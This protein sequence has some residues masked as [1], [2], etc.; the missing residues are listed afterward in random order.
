MQNI[1]AKFQRFKGKLLMFLGIQIH[2]SIVKENS[3]INI[4]AE[5]MVL[6]L[7]RKTN[8][9]VLNKRNSKKNIS[10][11]LDRNKCLFHSEEED[12]NNLNK[13]IKINSIIYHL[14]I[15]IILM[16]PWINNRK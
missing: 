9:T 12:H 6:A 3:I 8:V 13:K 5:M 1:R 7:I 14:N 16:Q 15:Q 10:I 11:H 2:P 4:V